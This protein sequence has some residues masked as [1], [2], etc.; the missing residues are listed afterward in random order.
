[1][2]KTILF[3]AFSALSLSCL[4]AQE[5]EQTPEQKSENIVERLAHVQDPLNDERMD[6][7]AANISEISVGFVVS[8]NDPNFNPDVWKQQLADSIK[9]YGQCISENQENNGFEQMIECLKKIGPNGTIKLSLDTP[10]SAG[11]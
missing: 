10:E 2:K 5:Q 3:F 8:K 11:N 9:F 7:A 1:M 4:Y 6:D